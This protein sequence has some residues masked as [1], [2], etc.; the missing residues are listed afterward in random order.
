MTGRQV[1]ATAAKATKALT[2]DPS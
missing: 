1:L 2:G